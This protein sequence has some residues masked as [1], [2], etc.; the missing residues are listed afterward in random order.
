M[1][2]AMYSTA[3]GLECVQVAENQQN[4]CTIELATAEKNHE[5]K[6]VK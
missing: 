4:L 3:Q 2:V 5:E 1:H 6:I